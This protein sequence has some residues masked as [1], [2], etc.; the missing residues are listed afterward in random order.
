MYNLDEN[1]KTAEVT[2]GIS[3][4]G[5][6]T[7]PSQITYNDVD[8]SV[9]K[10]GD[11]AFDDCGEL[12]SIAIPNSVT[13]IGIGAFEYCTGLTSIT[14]PYSVTIIDD[15][16]FYGCNRLTSI[17][18][19][20]GVTTIGDEAFSECSS[21]TSITIPKSVTSIADKA[22]FGCD[23]VRDIYC[24]ADP[25]KLTWNGGDNDFKKS[26]QTRCHVSDYDLEKYQSKF[27]NV[28]V[29]F[30]G[31]LDR[32]IAAKLETAGNES[33]INDVIYDLNGRRVE[34]L[35]PTGIYIKNGKKY[36]VK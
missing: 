33:S 20:E 4:S 14:I 6:I 35:L 23:I 36:I 24:H 2:E 9:T 22:F 17:V 32:L 30:F 5:S 10:I 28:N 21:L 25:Y 29:T 19:S 12:T 11:N 27:V 7:I 15:D 18:I 16:A 3:Y 26:K 1:H 31:D 13:S 34:G 8:Y